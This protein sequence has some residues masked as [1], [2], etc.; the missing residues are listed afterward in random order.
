MTPGGLTA[1]NACSFFRA[2]LNSA[3]IR[4]KPEAHFELV[5]DGG[6]EALCPARG[7]SE[8]MTAISPLL[9]LWRVTS[10]V[11]RFKQTSS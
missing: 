6:C 11:T 9:S 1:A 5:G 8:D 2:C 7:P 10:F 4:C 3:V